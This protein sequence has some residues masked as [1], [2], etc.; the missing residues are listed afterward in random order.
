MSACKSLWPSTSPVEKVV[1]HNSTTAK[2]DGVEDFKIEKV[3][4]QIGISSVTVERLAQQNKCEV[5]EGAGL[6]TPKGPVEIY[7]LPCANGQVFMA[8]CEFRQ[9]QAMNPPRSQ[10]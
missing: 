4:Y 8:R 7:R 2:A 9:C 5:K 10:E 1:A 6:L 3:P